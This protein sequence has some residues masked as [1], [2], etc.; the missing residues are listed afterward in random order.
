VQLRTASGQR[1]VEAQF[2]VCGKEE[3]SVIDN[4]RQFQGN[5]WNSF[6]AQSNDPAC[7]DPGCNIKQVCSIMLNAT[8]GDPL[9]RLAYLVNLT[10]GPDCMDAVYATYIASIQNVTV[11]GGTERIWLYQT[12]A[13]FGFFQTCDPDTSC[14]FTS[15]PWLV[16]EEWLV[17]QC[18]L[19][20]NITPAEVSAS[21]DATNAYYGADHPAGSHILFV[22]GD[23]DPWH[24]LSI[25][26]PLPNEP[27]FVVVGA[28]HHAWTHPAQPTDSPA[29]VQARVRISAY[30][31][32]WLFV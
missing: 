20:F 21:I 2:H 5:L 24:V 3:L 32:E 22:N 15:S 7:T 12:C 6:P 31:D 8:L 26:F 23:I 27:A 11:L 18:R 29:I 4:Q 10:Q 14:P 9:T 30:V 13:E 16:T 28:S 19:A 17:D 1:V 25:L